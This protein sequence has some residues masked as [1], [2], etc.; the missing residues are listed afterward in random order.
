MGKSHFDSFP[1]G[2]KFVDGKFIV[3][4]MDGKRLFSIDGV[5]WQETFWSETEEDNMDKILVNLN[6]EYLKFD[7]D[8][9]LLNDRTLV[10]M[11]LI[12]E[13]LGMN[14]MWDNLTDTATAADENTRI[15]FTVNSNTVYVNGKD[16]TI[17]TYPILKDDRTLIP[18]EISQRELR[19]QGFVE[20]Y[21]PDGN[22]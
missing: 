17:D 16:F 18:A 3:K 21:S 10:P 12:F 13:S 7:T 19:L 22:Y 11:R 5:N 14:V 6:G 2:A 4:Q 20:R 1:L 15:S 8:P 9:V